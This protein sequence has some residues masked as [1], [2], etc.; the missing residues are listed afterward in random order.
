MPQEVSDRNVPA[1]AAIRRAEV[2]V[3]RGIEPERLEGRR[4]RRVSSIAV[5]PGAT[6]STQEVCRERVLA[7][8]TRQGTRSISDAP[9]W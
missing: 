3:E 8:G 9:G 7:D 4:L 2:A 6:S 1:R 5:G